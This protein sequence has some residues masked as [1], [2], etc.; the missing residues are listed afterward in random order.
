V[1][2]CD[3][4]TDKNRVGLSRR[5]FL[6][7]LLGASAATAVPG[8]ALSVAWGA[9][10]AAGGNTLVVVF[11]RG[12]FDGLSAV[13]PTFDDDYYRARPSIAV[14]RDAALPLDTRFGLHPALAPL[15]PLYDQRILGVVHA[16]GMPQANRSHFSAMEEMERA[17]P[18]SSVRTG[19]L[20]RMLGLTPSPPD[21]QPLTGVS[22]TRG[23]T[24]GSVSGPFPETAVADLH[25][26][27]LPFL[28][29]NTRR[30]AWLDTLNRLYDGDV[31]GAARVDRAVDAIAAVESVPA[32]LNSTAAR[33]PSSA[34]GQGMKDAARLVKSAHAVSAITIDEGD[35]D[36]HAGLGS[37]AS[38]WMTEKLADLAAAISAFF[39]DIG[40]LRSNVTL[41]TMSEFGRR[42]MENSS[43]G[44]DHGWGNA[45]LVA[46]GGIAGGKVHG[47]WPGLDPANLYQGDLRVTVDYRSVLAEILVNRCGVSAADARSVFPGWSGTPL[48]VTLP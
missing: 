29:T 36:M 32:T 22:L 38:G 6:G 9:P 5:S 15:K 42:T 47:D 4:C 25:P 21:R 31:D 39:T 8:A 44:V 16:A 45:M 14:P 23:R 28:S 2:T 3:Q 7:A 30:Q 34:L 33:Y 46:G 13:A 40:S 24:P 11:L 35:W 18:G 10:G 41:V 48:G 26:I 43:G 1:D 19:W 20:D 37:V 12:G 27:D 17:A